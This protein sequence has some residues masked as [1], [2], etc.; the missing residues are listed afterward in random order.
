MFGQLRDIFMNYWQIPQTG[1]S[2]GHKLEAA[3]FSSIQ[4]ATVVDIKGPLLRIR[5]DGSEEGTDKWM[6]YESFDLYPVGEW[7]YY[8]TK[9]T[10]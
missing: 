7:K 9:F 8:C 3:N 1:F 10:I 4:P 2:I 5:I 6:H